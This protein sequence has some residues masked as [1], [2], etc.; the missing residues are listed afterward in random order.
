MECHR[1][2]AGV[3]VRARRP[4]AAHRGPGAEVPDD[5]DFE[6]LDVPTPG[7]SADRE[8]RGRPFDV[9]TGHLD[10]KHAAPFAGLRLIED[11]IPF[12]VEIALE[13]NL[14]LFQLRTLDIVTRGPF[15]RP[16]DERHGLEILRFHRGKELLHRGPRRG[17]PSGAGRNGRDIWGWSGM[18]TR[19]DSPHQDYEQ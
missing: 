6:I 16:P 9:A 2:A 8:D 17:R 3:V 18:V 19:H 4:L 1:A 14:A 10:V 12:R 5:R 15:D 7:R 11:A 13:Q